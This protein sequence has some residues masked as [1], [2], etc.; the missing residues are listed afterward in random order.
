M[1]KFKIGQKVVI[2]KD[3]LET[4]KGWCE[5]VCTYAANRTPMT[6]KKINKDYEYYVEELFYRMNESELEAYS[7]PICVVIR[8]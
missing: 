5:P 8:K 1:S 3:M 7:K 4:A 6:I 2:R